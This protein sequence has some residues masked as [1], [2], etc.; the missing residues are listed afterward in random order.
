MKRYWEND[1]ILYC[2]RVKISLYKIY[3]I[4]SLILWEKK[5][6]HHFLR[7]LYI[8]INLIRNIHKFISTYVPH[9]R[10]KLLRVYLSQ[11]IDPSFK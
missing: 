2:Q 8:R 6:N 5:M 3:K 1:F 7:K 11:W 10:H 9:M 4:S